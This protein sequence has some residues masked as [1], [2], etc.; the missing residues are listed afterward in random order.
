MSITAKQAFGQYIEAAE[1]AISTVR[2]PMLVALN[3]YG[4]T[5]LQKAIDEYRPDPM[6]LPELS[7][8]AIFAP[9]LGINLMHLALPVRL[10]D[11]FRCGVPKLN[12]LLCFVANDIFVPTTTIKERMPDGLT[13]CSLRDVPPHLAVQA[14]EALVK[15]PDADAPTQLNAMLLTDGVFIHAAKGVKVDKPIQIVNVDNSTFGMLNVRRVVVIAEEDAELKVL[16]CNHTERDSAH[17]LNCEVINVECG[18]DSGVELYHIDEGTAASDCYRNT[19]I[20]QEEGSH[21]TLSNASLHGG[22]SAYRYRLTLAGAGARAD[23]GGLAIGTDTRAVATDAV[24]THAAAGCTSRQLF[25]NAL[26]DS[27]RGSFGGK[28]IV[29]EGATATDAEQN[30]RNI[31]DGPKARMVTAPQLEIYCDDVKC[32]HG[33][34]TGSLD[35]RAMFYMQTRGIPREEARRMLTEAFMTDV[36]DAISFDVL[37]QRLRVLVEKRLSGSAAS[38]DTCATACHAADNDLTDIDREL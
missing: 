23:L 31:V 35:E 5:A 26:F 10:T 14:S 2:P 4:K 6:G 38:C 22:T 16:V 3:N 17:V 24:L 1:G 15:T 9:D 19:Y 33:A 11:A 25:K 37:R 8:V 27:A 30:N 20:R 13:V 21:F 7:P 34:T 12:S 36:I 29:K 32:S 28:I 18:K